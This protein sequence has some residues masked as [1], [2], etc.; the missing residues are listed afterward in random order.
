QISVRHKG[1]QYPKRQRSH[2][3][4]EDYTQI[5]VVAPCS[6]DALSEDASEQR[7][8]RHNGDGNQSHDHTVH[9]RRPSESPLVKGWP[10]IKGAVGHDDLNA[11]SN[12]YRGEAG[13]V[14]V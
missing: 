6:G 1:E 8:G 9:F 12:E 7:S 3:A 11:H 13:S 14:L 5:R 2:L 4:Q 10:P